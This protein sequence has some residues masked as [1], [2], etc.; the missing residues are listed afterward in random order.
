MDKLGSFILVWIPVLEKENSEFK[1]VK[2]RLKSD[3]VPHLA[4]AGGL[5]KY[6]YILCRNH[7]LSFSLLWM[8]LSALSTCGTYP[9]HHLSFSLLWMVLSAIC[10]CGTYRKHHLFF[11]L[12]W[13]VLSAICTCGTCLIH[14]LSFSL[15]WMVLSATCTCDTKSNLNNYSVI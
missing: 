11:S 6:M 13:M 12:L 4:L 7:H 1:P 9:K 10:T 5:G 14:H 15:L 8:V 3:L 2:H